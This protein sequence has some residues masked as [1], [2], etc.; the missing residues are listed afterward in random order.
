M[1]GR[2]A[3]KLARHEDAKE[4]DQLWEWGAAI[5]RE[6][7]C[8]K[9]EARAQF[10]PVDRSRVPEAFLARYPVGVACSEAM[11]THA[12]GCPVAKIEERVWEIGMR[13]NFKFRYRAF[14]HMAEDGSEEQVYERYERVPGRGD[15]P[16]AP[17]HLRS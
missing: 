7:V 4:L 15:P 1:N 3:R 11:I 6:R 10:V 12:P 5:N 2:K 9:C 16:V 13:N 14:A 8:P 17:E